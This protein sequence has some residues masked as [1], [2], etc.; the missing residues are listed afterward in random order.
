[1]ITFPSNDNN[2]S[3][4]HVVRT[5][6][7]YDRGGSI[8]NPV[9]GKALA[10]YLAEKVCGGD[11]RSYGV[12]AFNIR[13]Q[14]LIE[15]L[16]DER[17]EADPVFAQ[18]LA[19][20]EEKGEPLFVR[21]LESVQGDE[22]DVI[23][24]TIGFGPDRDGRIVMS[25][26]PL[27]K[28]GGWRRLNVAITRARDEMILFTSMDAAQMKVNSST[29]RGVADL[30]SFIAYAEGSSAPYVPQDAEEDHVSL[31][32]TASA[33]DGFRNQICSY[34]KELGYQY[35]TDLGASSLTIDIAVVDPDDPERYMLGILLG[36]S[37]VGGKFTLYDGEVGQPAALKNQGW[38]LLRL[39]SPD[40][41]ED[42]DR[43]KRRIAGRLKEICDGR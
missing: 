20:M 29:A 25:F 12:V 42:P 33:P 37:T 1:M 23:L 11:T 16:I 21:N 10:D 17:R 32:F 24:F 18:G 9:E 28:P 4:V 22:R 38:T 35:V 30:K 19:A 27:A 36:S 26:G 3:K 41:I 6:G 5:Q 14:H 40:W 8:T 39:W 34:L 15:Q 7:I 31:P 43:E 13:Q 2:V